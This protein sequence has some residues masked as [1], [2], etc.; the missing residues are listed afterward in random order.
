MTCNKLRLVW[1]ITLLPIL[2]SCDAVLQNLQKSHQQQT[3]SSL[4]AGTAPKRAYTLAF[5]PNKDRILPDGYANS[6]DM[7][8][9]TPNP[10]GVRYKDYIFNDFDIHTFYYKHDAPMWDNTKKDLIIDVITPRNDAEKK[11][12]CIIFLFGGGFAGKFDD[13]TQEIGKGFAQ[14]G[15]VVALP[16]YRIGYK[17]ALLA[18]QCVG[19]FETGMYPAYMRGVQ[20]VRS[21]IRYLKAN[22]DKFGIDKNK[23][24][25]SGHSAGALATIGLAVQTT[26][27]A[28]KNVLEQVGGSLDPMNDNMNYDATVAGVIALAGAVADP[29]VIVGKKINTPMHLIHGTCDELIDMYAGNPFRCKERKTF[30]IVYGGA[31]I[32]EAAKL[33]N[34]N[35]SLSVICNGSHS[36]SSIGYNELIDIM[37][38]FTYGI[39]SGNPIKGKKIFTAKKGICNKPELCK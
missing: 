29:N 25:V 21:A 14:K 30:P 34:D 22:A 39:I 38:D 1:L 6:G 10:W 12:P 13:C 5:P 17:N 28:P 19:D 33:N 4:N 20:D 37:N 2:S 11:R 36:M 7:L 31:A 9:T 15:Y 23:I 18:G 24:F 26:E 32:Y 35:V 16:D 3:A 27:N 8:V